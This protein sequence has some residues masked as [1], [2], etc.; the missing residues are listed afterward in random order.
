MKTAKITFISLLAVWLA[1]STAAVLA[2]GWGHPIQ[3]A[4]I[5]MGSGL[6]LLW[7]F[8]GGALM[9]RLR[10][11]VATRIH[12]IHLPW[13]LKFVSFATV[14]ALIE[15][16][17]TTSMTNLAPAFGVPLG[18]AYITSSV[19]YLDVVLR[20]SVIVFVPMFIAWAWLLK[21]YAFSPFQVF[22]LF[23]LSGLLAESMTFGAQNL[24]LFGMW[25]FVYGLMVYL[26]ACSIPTERGAAPPRWQHFILAVVLPLLAAMAVA[27]LILLLTPDHP[28]IHFPPIQG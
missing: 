23:G 16:A 7:V 28:D 5:G 9:V 15:E 19:N 6:V 21:R 13:P 1:A 27:G 4:V 8:L 22:L 20:H 2:I 26:P 14:L 10:L 18:S 12:A 11:P 25:I 3:R 24:F 17:I